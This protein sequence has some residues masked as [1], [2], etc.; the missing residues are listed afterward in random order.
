MI[1]EDVP[2]YLVPLIQIPEF[3][4]TVL[5]VFD[6]FFNTELTTG[7]GGEFTYSEDLPTINNIQQFI[8]KIRELLLFSIPGA[9]EMT[10][11][12]DEDQLYGEFKKQ[13]LKV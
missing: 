5:K 4:K 9:D 10:M 3:T 7:D 6:S 2:E 13:N 11:D 8:L 1:Y 12:E